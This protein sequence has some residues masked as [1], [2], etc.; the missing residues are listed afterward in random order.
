VC[1]FGLSRLFVADNKT[2][3]KLCGTPAYVAPE[4][5]QTN[6][7]GKATSKSDVYSLGIVLWELLNTALSKKYS[8]PFSEY[9]IVGQAIFAEAAFSKKRPTLP[10][11]C[12]V[13]LQQLYC[14]C[15]EEDP[16]IRPDSEFIVIT[17]KTARQNYNENPRS[18]L[19]P[20]D[21]PV[22]PTKT[23]RTLNNLSIDDS[24]PTVRS[25]PNI[26]YL[27]PARHLNQFPGWTRVEDGTV[28][29]A[30]PTPAK[31]SSSIIRNSR[32]I[33]VPSFGAFHNNV[34]EPEEELGSQFP[35]WTH[36]PM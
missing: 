21:S 22:T 24:I 10:R 28:S 17:L 19:S 11:N 18:F 2:L 31:E 6:E 4:I 33:M 30:P 34:K 25:S 7:Q 20:P 27:E 36:N 3:H 26:Y 16:N 35:G 1:D 23:D 12:P 9:G 5:F 29:S 32:N 15:V 8:A 14:L 13:I